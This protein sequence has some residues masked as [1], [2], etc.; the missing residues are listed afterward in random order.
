M[1]S[2]EGAK[3]SHQGSTQI[4]QKVT[5]QRSKPR[6]TRRRNLDDINARQQKIMNKMMKV[7][8]Q[9]LSMDMDTNSFEVTKYSDSEYR[10]VKVMAGDIDESTLKVKVSDGRIDISGETR[11]EEKNSGKYGS[12]SSS[13]V[14]SFN[15]SFDVP[16]LVKEETA[17][18]SVNKGEILIR[19]EKS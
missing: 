5:P 13:Y 10:Y 17:K 9:S 12:S 2:L 1:I 7:F 15:K 19:F 14:S 6:V 4:I 3:S 16:A 11:K 18:I 8:D